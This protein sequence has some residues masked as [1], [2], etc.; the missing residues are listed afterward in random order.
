MEQITE[1]DNGADGETE[2]PSSQTTGNVSTDTTN[3]SDSKTDSKTDSPKTGDD[4]NIGLLIEIMAVSILIAS[5]CIIA[6]RKRKA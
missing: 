5:G 4:T 1:K 6:A 2:G 3:T